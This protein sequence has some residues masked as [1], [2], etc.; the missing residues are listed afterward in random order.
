MESKIKYYYNLLVEKIVKKENFSLFVADN[1]L[2]ILKKETNISPIFFIKNDFINVIKNKDGQ[3]IT[4]IE[5][6]EYVVLKVEK[7]QYN[8]YDRFVIEHSDTESSISTS[9]LWIEKNKYLEQQILNFSMNKD[10]L[11]QSFDYYMGLAENAIAIMKKIENK[12]EAKKEYVCHRRIYYPNNTINYYDPTNYVID[13]KSRDIAEYIKS[14]FF[15]EENVKKSEIESFIKKYKLNNLDL[16]ILYAR[17]IYPTY[18]FDVF[19]DL[20]L[21]KDNAEAKQKLLNIINKTKKYQQTI[22][23]IFEIYVQ[24]STLPYIKWIN[25]L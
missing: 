15:K 8:I 9:S 14:W 4:N 11:I 19:E 24:D 2:Y 13:Y 22:T 5:N 1:N 23:D 3:Y 7:N 21:S 25:D 12:S 17:L 20:I 10:E 18:Y 6:I 16:L